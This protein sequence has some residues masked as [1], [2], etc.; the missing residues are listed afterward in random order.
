[1]R[2]GYPVITTGAR[3]MS[4]R[5]KMAA[6]KDFESKELWDMYKLR[7]RIFRDRMGWDIPVMSGMEIDGYDA[8]DPYY[9]TIYDQECNLKG[10]WRALPTEG[11]Y[12]LK[13]TFPELLHGADAPCNPKVW[14]LSR[15]AIEADGPQGFGFS[16]LS[17][18]ALREIVLFGDRMG[19]DAYVTVTTTSI[20]RMM[21]RANFGV[22]RFGPPIRIGVENAV[23]VVFDIGKQTHEAL[24][25]DY[26]QAA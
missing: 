23:A 16:G 2:A 1:M 24:F 18:D 26:P 10:C 13:D 9:M 4:Y 21:R 22:S 6:R 20:E 7:A 25:G 17:L 14:E 11:P 3:K 5:I 12:M 8:L 19:I 15:F